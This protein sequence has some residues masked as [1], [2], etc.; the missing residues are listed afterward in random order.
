[1]FVGIR[2]R[3]L[4]ALVEFFKSSVM[5]C[6]GD[7]RSERHHYAS[8]ATPTPSLCSLSLC[9]P[10]HVVDSLGRQETQAEAQ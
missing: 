10:R 8:C 1:M 6:V 9:V 3:L 7:G 4:S 2:P 5:M